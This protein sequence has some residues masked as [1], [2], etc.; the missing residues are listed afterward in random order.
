MDTNVSTRQSI[1]NKLLTLNKHDD[2]IFKDKLSKI[3]DELNTLI[4]NK[5]LFEKFYRYT[6]SKFR[7]D[8]V[9]DAIKEY[10][11]LDP[12]TDHV[13]VYLMDIEQYGIF[14][15]INFNYFLGVVCDKLNIQENINE[16]G[17]EKISTAPKIKQIVLK[18]EKQKMVIVCSPTR[19][20]DIE[21]A[22]KRFFGDGVR[23][24]R[25]IGPQTIENNI[26]DKLIQDVINDSNEVEIIVDNKLF[27]NYD[28]VLQNFQK[29]TD[30]C[31]NID[32]KLIGN[33]NLSR[34]KKVNGNE[35]IDATIALDKYDIND[36]MKILIN[37]DGITVNI[38][39]QCQV[40]NGNGDMN[41]NKKATPNEV[42]EM[43]IAWIRSNPPKAGETTTEYYLRYSNSN[44][45][46]ACKN[47]F[48]PLIKQY[49]GRGP[50]QGTN[51]R[52]W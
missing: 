48:G 19:S 44:K 34:M 50:T 30:E 24:I 47:K 4:S 52:H 31:D 15:P 13:L 46:I 22:A 33:A 10:S 2:I 21:S 29:F 20:A 25:N 7:F 41:I 17:L 3:D 1:I 35:Y 26:N 6:E 14:G 42:K 8:N 40:N 43:A 12:N 11:I 18:D 23:T 27:N 38:Y 9:S 45:Y 16:P 5:V 37:K 32:A 36:M 39:N 51:G 28:D 49:L